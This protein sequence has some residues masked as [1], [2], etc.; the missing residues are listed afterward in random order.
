MPERNPAGCDTLRILYRKIG[1]AQNAA[2]RQLM[3]DFGDPISRERTAEIVA[4]IE[5]LY[6][7]LPIRKDVLGADY[8]MEPSGNV[9]IRVREVGKKPNPRLRIG[10]T[11]PSARPPFEWLYELT[12]DATE[13]EYFKHYLVLEDEIV[14]AHLKVLT[15]IDEAEAQVILD[16]LG[17][18]ASL[19][20]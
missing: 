10:A 3:R 17:V 19:I 15:P 5:A 14:L 9:V 13:A 7:Q 16:D 20:D 1:T 6:E 2:E 18:A 4:A 8:Q 11:D 12:S